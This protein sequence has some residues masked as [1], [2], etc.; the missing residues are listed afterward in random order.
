MRNKS[1]LLVVLVLILT[2]Y[3]SLTFAADSTDSSRAEDTGSPLGFSDP[4]HVAMADAYKALM[5]LQSTKGDLE[6]KV[7]ALQT[8]WDSYHFSIDE[9]GQYVRPAKYRN[10]HADEDRAR[11]AQIRADLVLAQRDQAKAQKAWEA[12]KAVYDAKKQAWN[13]E[14]KPRLARQAALNESN[15]N[16]ERILNDEVAALKLDAK[17][18]VTKSDLNSVAARLDKIDGAIDKM[19]LGVYLQDKFGK[20]LNSDVFCK[21]VKNRCG[22]PKDKVVPIG[23]ADLETLFPNTSDVRR[24]SKDSWNSQHPGNEVK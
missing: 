23:D 20:L 16:K 6:A 1:N 11:A 17:F 12:Q 2:G 8:Q 18:Q 7:A 9:N 14:Q 24:S 4:L 19:M 22:T 15:K 5:P 3:C 13:D 10:F 21:A